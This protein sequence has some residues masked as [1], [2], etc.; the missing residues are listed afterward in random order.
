MKSKACILIFIFGWLVSSLSW[1]QNFQR[2]S[3]KEGFNQNT[4]NAIEIDKNGFIWFG[5]PN[6]LIK[7]DGYS[8]ESYTSNLSF[9]ANL[10]D[11]YILYII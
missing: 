5:T 6:G 3:N 9:Q 2:I 11:N 4:V 10:S 8:F 7:H 1:G